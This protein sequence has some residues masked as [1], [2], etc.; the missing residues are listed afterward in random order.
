M[1][2][3]FRH[4]VAIALCAPVLGTFLGGCGNRAAMRIPGASTSFPET[5]THYQ[6][7]SKLPFALV[8]AACSDHRKE[9]YGQRIAGTEWTSV[10][11][12][13]MGGADAAQLIRE[14]LVKE[15]SS[16]GLF[17]EVT[18]RD[19][20]PNDAILKTEIQAFSCQARG[21]LIV[22]VVGMTALH[23]VVERDGKTL[24]ER[25][26][27]KV[28]TDADKEYTGSQVTFIEQAMKVTMTDSLR[29]TLKDLLNAIESSGGTWAQ[30]VREKSS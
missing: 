16:S 5:A 15:L 29:E 30:T 2:T 26:F 6:A 23:V 25:T 4:V 7:K 9:H 27:E 22:R 12:D 11:T 3:R 21:F 8:V 18:T 28:V 14:R 20:G 19:P 17:S 10:S 24:M 1:T 13:A